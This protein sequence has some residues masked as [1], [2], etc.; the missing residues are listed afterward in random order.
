MYLLTN[1]Y[2]SDQFKNGI[3]GICD[4]YRGRQ[5]GNVLL[6]K[7]QDIKLLQISFTEIIW[8]GM[9]WAEMA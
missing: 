4:M 8:E 3:G 6:G 5:D 9:G 1:Y 7:P 2:L